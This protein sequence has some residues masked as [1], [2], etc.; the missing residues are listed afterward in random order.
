MQTTGSSGPPAGRL[1]VPRTLIL[2]VL[3]VLLFA[4][5]MVA[6]GVADLYAAFGWPLPWDASRDVRRAEAM[7]R[8]A[9]S[10][11]VVDVE[12]DVDSLDGDSLFIDVVAGAT[13][14]QARDA[15]CSVVLPT[16]IDPGIVLLGPVDVLG[17]WAA[18]ADCEDPSSIPPLVLWP[19][20]DP[21]VP[22]PV[23]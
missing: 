8:Q 21:P 11:F 12:A 5:G 13:D 19:S 16:G 14:Q 3:A 18:P 17:T 20:N 23:P 1:H 9:A 22:V 7:I 4:A 2:V 15:W 6:V 10:P